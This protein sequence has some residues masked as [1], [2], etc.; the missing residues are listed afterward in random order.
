MV[1]YFLNRKNLGI[2]NASGGL[3]FLTLGKYTEESNL[4]KLLFKFKCLAVFYT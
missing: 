3:A 4:M 2:C 1:F